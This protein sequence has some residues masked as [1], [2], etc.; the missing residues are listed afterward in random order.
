MN[1]SED[2]VVGTAGTMASE[3]K[4]PAGQAPALF[5]YRAIEHDDGIV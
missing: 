4:V 2:I 3:D 1:V 5:L